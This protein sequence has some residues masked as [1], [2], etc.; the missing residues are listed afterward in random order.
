MT[1]SVSVTD[2][3]SPVA[4]PP[5]D[6]TVHRN[7]FRY[8]LAP[9]RGKP[10]VQDSVCP[11]QLPATSVRTSDPVYPHIVNA[12][13]LLS[14]EVSREASLRSRSLADITTAREG[15]YRP[16]GSGGDGFGERD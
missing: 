2:L 7:G 12:L 5:E 16:G 4:K 10:D 6:K 11:S 3:T 13:S 8:K 1:G 9:L 15:A 14:N